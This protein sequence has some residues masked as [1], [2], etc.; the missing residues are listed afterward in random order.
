M[1]P[2]AW[3]YDVCIPPPP[4]EETSNIA[5]PY[6]EGRVNNAA[7]TP[8]GVDLPEQGLLGATPV[9][10]PDD[11]GVYTNIKWRS[12]EWL[13]PTR[14]CASTRFVFDVLPA[15][16]YDPRATDGKVFP[17]IVYFHENGATHAWETGSPIDTNVATEARKENFHFVSVEF[18]HPVADQYLADDP[19]HTV[20]HT[21]VGLFIQFLRKNAAKFKVDKR[22]IFAFGRSRGSLALWQGLQADMGSGDT[23]SKVNAFVGYEAQTSYQCQTFSNYFLIQDPAAQAY[24][25]ECKSDA[26]NK[27]D[28]LFRNALDSVTPNTTLPVM[29]QYSGEFVRQPNGRVKKLTAHELFS[30]YDALHY[31]N[32]G[33]ALWSAYND[34]NVNSG[35]PP[36]MREP[37]QKVPKRAQFIGWQD[38]VN[39]WRIQ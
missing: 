13:E 18:R 4:D 21:D 38:F 37:A 19:P 32:F 10:A 12:G 34:N 35:S 24:V 16:D 3:A 20:P 28:P 22:N 30:S 27:Y 7:P 17:V 5:S 39:D 6:P 36:L 8:M 14:G 2:V 1:S 29:L 31:P 11:R 15:K 23:S 25:N 9:P 26:K 33:V